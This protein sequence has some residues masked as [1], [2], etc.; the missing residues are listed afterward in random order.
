MSKYKSLFDETNPDR[1]AQSNPA[2]SQSLSMQQ[3]VTQASDTGASSE[4]KRQVQQSRLDVVIEEEES[5]GTQRPTRRKRKADTIEDVPMADAEEDA[6]TEGLSKSDL[7]KIALKRRQ[8]TLAARKS[9]KRKLEHMMYLENRV[10]ELERAEKMWKR[11]P[12]RE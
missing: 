6:S 7:D 1:V 10:E 12:K 3:S 4:A 5:L 2:E 11:N 9:R 8:N